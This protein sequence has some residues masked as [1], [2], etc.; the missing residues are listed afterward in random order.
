VKHSQ[1]LSKIFLAFVLLVVGCGEQKEP[2]R[3]SLNPKPTSPGGGGKATGTDDSIT[4]VAETPVDRPVN[5]LVSDLGHDDA[6]SL[7]QAAEVALDEGDSMNAFRL[8]RRARAAA[9]NDPQTKILM[10]R[11]LAERN[12]FPEAIKMLDDLLADLPDARLPILGQTADW[13]VIN[14]QWK[15]AE[16]RYRSILKE[17]PDA[18]MAERM[19]AELW[20][21]QGRRL[22]AAAPLRKLCR[23]GVVDPSHLRALLRLAYPLGDA[24]RDEESDE[25]DEGEPIGPLGNARFQFGQGDLDRALESLELSRSIS[26]AQKALAGRIY[27]D[28]QDFEMLRNWAE[29][30]DEAMTEAADYWYALGVLHANQEEH[31]SAVKCLCEA[32][33]LD[34]TDA[35]AYALMG[36]SL[37]ELGLT[38]ESLAA[39]KRSELI[40]KTQAIGV[41]LTRSDT[42]SE[43][44]RLATL[45]GLLDQLRRPFEA[46]GWRAVGVTQQHA[47]AMLSDQQ[48]R[49]SMAEIN[50]DRVK[51]LRSGPAVADEAFLRCG[52]DVASLD[53]S[54]GGESDR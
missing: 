50:Q 9:P 3:E 12:R 37:G 47:L 41:E 7:Y 27:A 40:A 52:V 36:R 30:R 34:P 42:E 20:L 15:E 33:S 54:D 43:S 44:E 35:L 4:R 46:F 39:T 38:T 31:R 24:A 23:K 28:Q 53:D 16:R 10:A 1:P 17:A 25:N 13:M 32:V 49:A 8:V 11:V 51:L 5:D 21:R 26:P 19:L 48:A 45:A 29:G 6:G 14:G 2:A 22:E 18:S